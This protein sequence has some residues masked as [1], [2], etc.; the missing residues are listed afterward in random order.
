MSALTVNLI[1]LT[2]LLALWTDKLELT[3]NE[4]QNTTLKW[5]C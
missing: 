5:A 2:V 1:L 4:C 3:F